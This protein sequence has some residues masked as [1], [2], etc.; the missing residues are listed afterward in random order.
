MK[1]PALLPTLLAAGSLAA[2]LLLAG[3]PARDAGAQAPGATP[4]R[5]VL[6]VPPDDKDYVLVKIPNGGKAVVTDIIAYNSA[7]GNGHKVAPTAESYLWVGGYVDGKSVGLVNR[8]R[9]LGNETE[10]WHLETGLELSGAGELL[11]SSE[12]EAPG[13][14]PALVYV[15]GYLTR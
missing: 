12:K 9:V 5:H 11:V 15:T 14:S 3:L 8:M 7:D 4:F 2:Y 10:Q 1:S 6:L 13:A